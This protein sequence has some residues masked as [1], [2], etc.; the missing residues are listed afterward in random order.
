MTR[1]HPDT[2]EREKEWQMLPRVR[3]QRD[4]HDRGF[5]YFIDSGELV[6]IG[7]TIYPVERRLRTLQATSPTKLRLVGATYA[8][9]V[10]ERRL[11]KKFGHLRA[12]GEW[13]RK[14]PEL[15]AIMAVFL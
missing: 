11:H 12:H 14:A 6:K 13:F 5:V 1:P 15:D 3:P 8:H 9:K 4:D 10:V 2:L 7:F